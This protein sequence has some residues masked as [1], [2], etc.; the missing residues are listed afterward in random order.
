MSLPRNYNFLVFNETGI[1]I[2]VS[3][4][5]VSARRYNF[6]TSGSIVYEIAEATVY[7]N[8]T[9]IADN[10]FDVGT[11][12]NQNNA[13]SLWVGGDFLYQVTPTQSGNGNLSLYL[14]RSTDGGTVFDTN[15]EALLVSVI[16]HV[17]SEEKKT[18]FGL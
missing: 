10:A 15:S 16:S 14:A 12:N 2:P 9:S 5:V 11:P 18:G 13:N 8:N 1:T 4:L 7:T 6:S 17:S 3:E